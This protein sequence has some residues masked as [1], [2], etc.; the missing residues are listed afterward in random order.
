MRNSTMTMDDARVLASILSEALAIADGEKRP[1]TTTAAGF[2]AYCASRFPN[3]AQ[4]L[5][6]ALPPA[7][8]GR[9]RLDALGAPKPALEAAE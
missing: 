3:D 9:T 5:L 7:A 1:D 6:C 2:L 4:D 8:R